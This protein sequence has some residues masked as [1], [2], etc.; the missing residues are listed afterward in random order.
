[1]SVAAH[2]CPTPRTA[3]AGACAPK[4]ERERQII[5]LFRHIAAFRASYD[6]TLLDEAATFAA[7]IVGPTLADDLMAAAIRLD[8]EMRCQTAVDYA[9]LPVGSLER[10]D[11][12]DAFLG[13][14]LALSNQAD[15]AALGLAGRL[16]VTETRALFASA[17]ALAAVLGWP[18][19]GLSREAPVRP[20]RRR[21]PEA[22]LAYGQA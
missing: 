17:R 4:V 22:H 19:R 10:H 2:A 9:P 3:D 6:A 1:M 16:G 11:C 14:L 18:G 15:R 21:W 8:N 7:G 12:E 13:M 5:D 20:R